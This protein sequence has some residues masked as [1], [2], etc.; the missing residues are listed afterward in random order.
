MI[1]SRTA[2]RYSTR[3]RFV[4]FAPSKSGWSRLVSLTSSRTSS[5]IGP[6]SHSD[7]G[8][9]EILTS[10][11]LVANRHGSLSAAARVSRRVP[12]GGQEHQRISSLAGKDLLDLV[13]LPAGLAG[14]GTR[15][16]RG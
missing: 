8:L 1:C 6:P 7:A 16:L 14:S 2:S 9:S 12:L 11:A 10:L 4:A 3:S 13:V 15:L 5:L